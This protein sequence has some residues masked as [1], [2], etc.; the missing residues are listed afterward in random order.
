MRDERGLGMPGLAVRVQLRKGD[1]S[2]ADAKGAVS[3]IGQGLYAF[4]ASEADMDTPGP[5][6]FCPRA[7]GGDGLA[8][9]AADIVE[10][11]PMAAPRI[12]EEG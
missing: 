1:N 6:I 10:Y 9:Y 5:F 11:D 8:Q 2:W 7:G 4:D 3:E 12:E